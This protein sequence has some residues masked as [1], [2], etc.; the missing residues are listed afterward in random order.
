VP[1]RAAQE[2]A[3]RLMDGGIRES[4]I[5][6]RRH[7]GEEQRDDPQPRLARRMHDLRRCS[8]FVKNRADQA[9]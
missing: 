4:S 7:Q 5:F 2:T 6:S 8:R 1:A 9:V 3:D